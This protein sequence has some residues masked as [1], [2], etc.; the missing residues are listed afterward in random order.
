[1]ISK[2]SQA[3]AA[4]LRKLEAWLHTYRMRLVRAAHDRGY[5]ARRRREQ[6]WIIRWLRLEIRR[7]LSLLR[8][9]AVGVTTVAAIV[10][11]V[12]GALWWR[13]ANGP[14]VLDVVTPWLTSAIEKNL[15]GSHH[16]DVGGTV[17]ERDDTGRTA[18]R[19]RDITVRNQANEVIATAP[20]AE[21]GISGIS[22]LMGNPRVI[23]F[24]LVGAN[25]QIMIEPDGEVN[26]YAGGRHP[27]LSVAAVTAGR[28][29]VEQPSSPFSL[30]AIAERGFE[31]NLAAVLGW[32]DGLGALGRD[33]NAVKLT[34]FDGYEL[35]EV[36]VKNGSLLVDDARNAR[37]WTFKEVSLG[38]TR[39]PQGGVAFRASSSTED[40]SWS[41]SSSLMPL[42]DGRRALQFEARHVMLDHVLLAMQLGD[43]QFQ[44]SLPISADIRADIAP[45]GM[46]EVLRG[47]VTADGY[48]GDEKSF[49][50]R[51]AVEAK[52]DLDWDVARGTLLAP[53]ELKAGVNR[54]TLYTQLTPPATRDGIMLFNIDGGTVVLGPLPQE[55]SPL[56]LNR[57]AV[58][59]RHDLA[60][61][62]I[63][64]ERAQ[65]ATDDARSV[66]LALSGSLDYARDDPVLKLGLTGTQM[67][68]SALK[69][70]WPSFVAPNVR[71]WIMQHLFR[72]YVENIDIAINTPVSTLPANG[73]SMTDDAI[74]IDAAMIGATVRPVDGL[75]LI[76]DADVSVHVTGRTA[77]VKL[78]K[79]TADISS[80]RR[81]AVSNVLFEIPDMS[82]SPPPA[83]VR[84]KL[85]GPVPAAAELMANEKLR[86]ISGPLLDPATSRGLMT[87]QILL[88]LPLARELPKGSV[89]FNLNVDLTNFSAERMIANKKVE[90]ALLRVTASNQAYSIKGDVKIDGIPAQLEYRK[91]SGDADAEVRIGA[92]LDDAARTR[93]GF[94]LGG[95][96][97][98][99]VPVKIG[100]RVGA[101]AR[102]TRYAVE[103]DFTAARIDNLI[104]GWVKPPGRPTRAT[105]TLVKTDQ[106]TRFED[107]AVDG[108]GAA[109]RGIIE[110]DANN[111]L[112]SANF[113]NF[114]LSEG[115]KGTL[116]ADR[117][118]DGMIRVVMRSDIFDVRGFIKSSMSGSTPDQ[119]QKAQRDLDVDV[120]ISRA[121]GG[122]GEALRTVEFKMTRRGGHVRAFALNARIGRDTPLKG[123]MRDI[124]DLR[125]QR[126]GRATNGQVLYLETNDA[127]ALFRFG[128]IYQHMSGGRLLVVM[129]P[130]GS[131]QVPQEGILNIRDFTI[132]GETQLE[133]VLPNQP[134]VPRD[135]IAFTT[136]NV[137]FTRTPGKLALRDGVVRGPVLGLTIDGG[138]DYQRDE[139][140]LRG[141]FVPL[142]TLNNAIT[143]IPIVGLVLGGGDPNSGVF[144][145]TYE[146]VGTPGQPVMRIN[147]ASVLAPGILR[148]FFEFPATSSNPTSGAAVPG[149]PPR[150]PAPLPQQ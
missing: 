113:T 18:L 42:R 83:R 112:Q 52:I 46:P 132:T 123:D 85:E 65:I 21:I 50:D 28:A 143:Q 9:L 93:L 108:S 86:D 122:Y 97:T 22:L 81:L 56:V 84:F 109:L 44:S 135:N 67:N 88:N 78:G 33:G 103:A 127:G 20:R 27:F 32:V 14:I 24:L 1:M 70:L 74:A 13:L 30:K 99:A 149:V 48:L 118:Q 144:G 26:V 7:H 121:L 80:G 89:N 12:I 96:V 60:R 130:P 5:A 3:R 45:N 94:D 16:I 146:V 111:E 138:L 10:A 120:K 90:A 2:L 107:L 100:T 66:G 124:R 69:R 49:E 11:L 57:V 102:D 115:D 75:P 54:M 148:K 133:G 34:G 59:I 71:G 77:T 19:L 106:G 17:L 29:P 98:G 101:N 47:R 73:P 137:D 40:R 128:D 4:V 79:G 43:G 142:Y 38:L 72:G 114:A 76:R 95:A 141:T 8:K 58:R 53:V 150:P 55:T 23:S 126:V 129:D 61:Q 41:L 82:A 68:V 91:A 36:G 64:L 147:P 140:R 119:K 136:L 110:I 125:E 25:M 31:K 6:H 139:V 62:L 117:G 15:G 39:P 92:M 105:F 51:V 63:E 37:Q 104:P 145:V 116:K 134:N 131:D 35:I 87:A